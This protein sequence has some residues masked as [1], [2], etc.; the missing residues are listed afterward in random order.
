MRQ[1]TPTQRGSIINAG[2]KITL[3]NKEINM[4]LK[5]FT[6]V[7]TSTNTKYAVFNG[8]TVQH[9]DVYKGQLEITVQ[10]RG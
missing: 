10:I 1:L 5:T 7:N 4:K 2:N 3:Q 8:A 9:V 6:K